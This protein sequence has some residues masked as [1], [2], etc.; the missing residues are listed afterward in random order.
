MSFRSEETER[1]FSWLRAGESCQII[2]I[3]S[4]GK[5]NFLHFL[6]QEDVRRAKF[7]GEW[8]QYLFIYVDTNKLLEITEVG[9]WELML[10]Q[11][12]VQLSEQKILNEVV[13]EIDDLYQRVVQPSSQ[14]VARRF[15]DRAVS[16][17]CNQLGLRLVYLFDE[18]DVLY[19]TLPSAVF[20]TLRALRDEHKYKLMY[21]LSTRI[22]LNRIR[23]TEESLSAFEKL[24]APNRLWLL[25]YS[26]T[27][28][29]YMM[30]RLA[31]RYGRESDLK[32]IRRALAVT[33]GHPGLIR[34]VFV[35]LRDRS[36]QTVDDLLADNH[37]QEELERIW[38]GLTDTEQK[39]LSLLVRNGHIHDSKD[40]IAQLMEKGLLGGSWAES[41][42]IF[43]PLFAAYIK[44]K[45]TRLSVQIKIDRHKHIVWVDSRRIENIPLLEFKLLEYLD[46]RRGQVCRRDQIARYLYPEQMLAGVSANALYSV[47]KR[48]RK[49]VE[50]NPR[51]PTIILTVRGVGFRLGDGV[52]VSEYPD[53]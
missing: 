29:R 34:S 7:R 10:H 35:L 20:M 44:K 18:F 53:H 30:M 38:Q 48:L 15:L 43:S 25:A 9:L 19:R 47:V 32:K 24:I 49:L 28:G 46:R 36:N 31:D 2:G 51:K 37:V 27:D 4:V 17:I 39:A 41:D 50:G 22:E 21:V 33:G 8:K 45:K 3:G 11:M 5:S 40:V 1:V 52:S 6:R 16:I 42:Q 23:G 26:E 13:Q 12:L 14:H